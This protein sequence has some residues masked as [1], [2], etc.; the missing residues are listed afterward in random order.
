VVQLPRGTVS[1][2][3]T[4]IEGSTLL[5]HRLQERYRE[6][7]NEHRR[8]LEEAIEANGG[9]VVDR[10]TE[11]FFAV[12]PRMRD[13]A[14]AAC[15]AQNSLATHEWPEGAQVKVR[16]GIHAGEPEL[17]GDRYVGLAVARAARI[18]ATAHGGQVIM[19]GTARG[20]LDGRFS[21][22]SLGSYPLK[23]FDAPEPLYQLQADGLAERFPRPRV[24]PR[25]SHRTL[26]LIGAAIVGL[27]IAAAVAAVIVSRS[28]AGAS[29]VEANNVGVIDPATNKV[30]DQ[31]P[32]GNRPGPIAFGAGSVWV[33]NI[34]DRNLIRL[35]A[36]KRTNAGLVTLDD[37][38][39]TGIAYG[40]REGLWVA[41]GLLGGLSKVDPQFGQV[42]LTKKIGGPSGEGIGEVAVGAGSVWA[43]FGESTIARVDPAGRLENVTIAPFS[44]TAV[45]VANDLLWIASSG[46]QTVQV[47]ALDTFEQGPIKTVPVGRGPS[48]LAFGHGAMWVSNTG[49]DTVT[50]IDPSS[51]QRDTIDVGES[52]NALAV[53][54]EAIWVANGGGTV[55]RIDPVKREVAKTIDVGNVP[56]G[57]AVGAGN[58]WVSV[59]SP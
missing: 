30:V 14:A 28:G 39:P 42:T 23:D 21:A 40:E 19:S 55:S 54:P 45:A 22:R 20:L 46:D 2:L 29:L 26:I 41:H 53:S 33:G 51:F 15:A 38:T 48:A 56:A 34:V 6:V 1:L 7:V 11:S 3:F 4:D 32:V 24:T 27:V 36:T 44:P 43:A 16:M 10:Q 49:D 8:L 17:E 35:D 12:F 58:V 37:Q 50:R 47:F 13:A 5:Q 18:G 25:R 31:V 9:R 57:I 52:P 59:Q